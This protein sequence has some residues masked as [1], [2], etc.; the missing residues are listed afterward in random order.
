MPRKQKPPS[1]SPKQAEEIIKEYQKEIARK[2]GKARAEKL[3]P[4]RRK[5]IADQAIRKR[6]K[7]PE[8]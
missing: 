3:T 6:W 4:E 8:D 1:V 2:G 7:K 5:E